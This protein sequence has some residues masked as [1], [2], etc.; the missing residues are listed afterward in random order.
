VISAVL[1]A[2]DILQAFS[3]SEPYLT[4]GDISDRLGLPKSTTHN[5][6]NT[7]LS[8]GLVEK[9]DGGSYALG[10]AI[11]ALAHAARVNLEL[12]DRAAPFIREL[13]YR[14]RESVYLTVVDRGQSLYIYAVE[15]P[16]RLLAGTAMGRR[17]P[18]HC[19]AVGKAMLAFLPAHEVDEVVRTVGLPAF[20][21]H[22]IT[23]A[24]A[25]RSE[26]EEIRRRGYALD[27]EE[28]ELGTFCVGAP[29][30]GGHGQLVAGCSISGPDRE[31]VGVRLPELSSKVL[32]T[33][34]EISRLM[35]YV[36]GRAAAQAGR[37]VEGSRSSGS[38]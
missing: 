29:I 6:L 24:D 21:P 37:V 13:A 36:P 3:Q 15:S 34:Q 28:H 32:Q 31:I 16:R 27:R 17:V 38:S 25:L 14:C 23:D 18:L 22:T 30:L 12:R 20:T 9:V 35:G 4:L 10:N 11:I 1:K 7:L 2:I 5:I 19:T 33:A 26:M 8:R